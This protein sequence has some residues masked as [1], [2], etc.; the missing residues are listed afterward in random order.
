M[1]VV[2]HR[3]FSDRIVRRGHL[4]QDVS[5]RLVC[6]LVGLLDRTASGIDLGSQVNIK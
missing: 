3:G 5:G 1:H 4:R 2:L 6:T